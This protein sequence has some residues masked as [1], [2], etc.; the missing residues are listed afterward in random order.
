MNAARGEHVLVLANR[1][2]R[3]CLT[4]GALAEIET[5]L[6]CRSM[7]E[8]TGRLARLSA[9]DLSAVLAALLRGAGEDELAARLPELQVSPADAAGAVAETFR[10]ALEE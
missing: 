6:E 9:R 3:L 5:A 7:S 2:A 4:L 1:R 8:L 10:R